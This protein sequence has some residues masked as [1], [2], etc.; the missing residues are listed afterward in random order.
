MEMVDIRLWFVTLGMATSA[1]GVVCGVVK[2][3]QVLLVVGPVR[4]E[5]NPARLS[6]KFVVR[7]PN[8]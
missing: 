8:R 6:F 1:I 5:S 4:L 2:H 3:N 7:R